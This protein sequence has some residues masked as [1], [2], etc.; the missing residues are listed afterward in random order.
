[1]KL[2]EKTVQ[3]AEPPAAGYSLLRDDELKGFGVR[4]TSKGSK[5]FVLGYTAQGRERRM[6]LG[7]WPA[8]TVAAARDRAKELKRQVEKGLDPQDE[9]QQ[10]KEESTFADLLEEYERIRVPDMKRGQDV[11]DRL[12]RDALPTL[13][14]RKLSDITRRD[15]ITLL[16][17]KAEK[18]KISANRTHQAINAIF[19]FGVKRALLTVNPA[20]LID[21]P[22]GKEQ[23]RDRVLSF[24][25]IATAWKALDGKGVTPTVRDIL[26]MILLTGQRPGEVCTLEWQEIEDGFWNMPADKA[27]SGKPQR[28][29][30]VGLAASL[31]EARERRRGVSWVF[32]TRYRSRNAA[33]SEASVSNAVQLNDCF[34]IPHWT[35]HDLRRTAASHLASLKVLP[36]VID[37]ILNH[38]VKGVTDRHYNLYVYDSEKREALTAWN[39][40]LR[41]VIG[42]KKQ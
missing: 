36:H 30:V 14:R 5:S 40:K 32:P 6:T 11:M 22:G 8:W 41:E 23:P 12:N 19:N 42:G 35:P 2:N 33:T 34:D 13:G 28:V 24:S 3:K 27:K 37:R 15:I 16:D 20:A 21:P 38:A 29:P 39:A 31:L 17:K 10:Q 4:I 26:R 9:R 25:E 7:T 1:M 18:A